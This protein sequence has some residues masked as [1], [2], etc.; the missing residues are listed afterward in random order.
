MKKLIIAICLLV[1]INSFSQDSTKITISPQTRDLEYIGSFIFND[2]STEELYDSVKL[3]FRVDTPPTGNTT[4]AITGYT[5]DWISVYDRLNN[6]PVALKSLCVK[7]IYDL[8]L[9][10]NQSY[11]TSKLSAID[12]EDQTTF[13]ALRQFGRSKIRRK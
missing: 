9:A 5:G 8:L 7:R 1:S 13:Q 6:D 2:N 3:N 10:V 12:Q 4:V 11:L